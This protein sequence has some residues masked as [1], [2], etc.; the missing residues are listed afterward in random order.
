[1]ITGTWRELGADE[2]DVWNRLLT[3]ALRPRPALGL[4]ARAIA[5]AT[6]GH[7]RQVEAR[8]GGDWIP[9]AGALE[10][11]AVPGSG[12]AAT[13]ALFGGPRGAAEQGRRAGTDRDR[14]D[15]PARDDVGE[16]TSPVTFAAVLLYAQRSDGGRGNLYSDLTLGAWE[17]EELVP[18]A[19]VAGG[20][21][22]SEALELDRWVRRNAVDKFGPVRHVR[23]ELVF[24]VGCEAVLPSSRH[25][26]GLTVRGARLVRWR[27][28]LAAADGTALAALR[29]RLETR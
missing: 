10:R 22:A 21:G 17:G 14:G 16:V 11:L 9:G 25:K 12:P 15:A 19:K 18:V 2:L 6:G 4:V 23:P 3:G 7:A 29:E 24:E 28:D 26:A 8:L 5:A 1:V 20:L 27:R 13:G